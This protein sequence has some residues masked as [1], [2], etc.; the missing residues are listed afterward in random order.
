MIP[1]WLRLLL[2]PSWHDSRN[3]MLTKSPGNLTQCSKLLR[4]WLSLSF[5]PKS[6]STN[7][8]ALSLCKECG[9]EAS[10]LLMRWWPSPKLSGICWCSRLLWVCHRRLESFFAFKIQQDRQSG[11]L[12]FWVFFCHLLPSC[13]T[14]KWW[15][16]N[17][18]LKILCSFEFHRCVCFSCRCT[19]HPWVCCNRGQ[20]LQRGFR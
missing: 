1:R 19:E 9:F 4:L 6:L 13:R 16:Q 7:K 17:E 11:A 18:I 2:L 8:S 14:E 3:S 5:L 15:R 10:R 12:E 20:F